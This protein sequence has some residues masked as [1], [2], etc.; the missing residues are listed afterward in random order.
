MAESLLGVSFLNNVLQLSINHGS[1]IPDN[2]HFHHNT[3]SNYFGVW[4]QYYV[5]ILFSTYKNCLQPLPFWLIFKKEWK[6][7]VVTQKNRRDNEIELSFQ[8]FFY[9][10]HNPALRLVPEFHSTSCFKKR[11]MTERRLWWKYF[12]FFSF[13]LILNSKWILVSY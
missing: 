2:T 8:E 5:I 1:F 4:F 10:V 7:M 12:L 6:M 9:F 13:F 3:L 11:S